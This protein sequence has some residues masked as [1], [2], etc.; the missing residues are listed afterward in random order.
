MYFD[1]SDEEDIAEVEESDKFM[2]VFFVFDSVL[3]NS[4][5]QTN[6]ALELFKKIQS[7]SLT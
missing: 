7:E 5:M 2:T 1:E 4:E 3:E 6:A